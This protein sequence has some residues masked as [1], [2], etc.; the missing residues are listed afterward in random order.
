MPTIEINEQFQKAIDILENSKRNLLI[1]GKAGTGKSTFLNHFRTHSPKQIAVLAPTGVA[2]INVN[3]MTIHSFCGFSIDITLEKVT[4][5]PIKHRARK[6]LKTLDTIVID[7]ISMVRADILDCINK[8]LILNGPY[9]KL[10]FGGIQMVFIGDL[11]QI[12]PIVKSDVANYFK[13]YYSSPYFFSAKIFEQTGHDFEFIEFEKIY[14]QKDQRFVE[15]LNS[16]RNNSATEQQLQTLNQRF[17]A[18]FTSPDNE[19][20][21][22]ITGT[23]NAVKNLNDTMLAKIATDEVTFNATINGAIKKDSFPTDGELRLKVGS[24]IMLV[25]NDS[26]HR[27]VNGTIAQVIGFKLDK[28]S[29]E[30][31]IKIKLA[32]GETVEV[33]QHTWDVFKYEVNNETNRLTTNKI[34]S[35]TQYPM[36]LAWAITVHK[37]QGKTFDNIIVDLGVT[38]TPGQMYVAL[39]RCTSLNGL[40]LKKKISKQNIFIDHRIVNFMTKFQYQRAEATLSLDDKILILKN[41][42]ANHYEI[43]ITY[44][45][46]HDEKSKRTIIPT[47]IGEMSY[48][49]KKFLGLEG[50]CTLR[51]ERRNFRVDRILE[52]MVVKND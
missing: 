11:Y 29:N 45:K 32:S 21:I 35:F 44:L 3:G 5:L 7:E 24:Q 38:F 37:S 1:F 50:F 34:G 12:P 41:A 36:K 27:W 33:C 23:N 48:Q 43:E 20:W 4:K 42:I 9:S 46:V 13:N 14:R 10:P 18:N 31:I 15:L 19:F 6:I 47:F 39:S 16:I 22:H 40:I 51:K 17:I 25:N 49:N 52:L 2:A 26:K 8:F 30:A 28:E